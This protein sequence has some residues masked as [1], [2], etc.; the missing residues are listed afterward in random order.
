MIPVMFWPGIVVAF[1][2]LVAFSWLLVRHIGLALLI[3]LSPLPG[4]L[5]VAFEM[6]HSPSVFGYL[7]GFIV[8]AFLGAVIAPLAANMPARRAVSLSLRELWRPFL[9]I[10]VLFVP[11]FF[12]PGHF[13]GFITEV[14]AIL[15]T[16]LGSML[17]SYNENFVVRINRAQE[18]RLRESE[19]LAFLTVPRW[20]ASIS[21]AALVFSALSFFGAQKGFATVVAR[22][23]LFIAMTVLFL[24]VAFF[25]ARNVRRAIA[26]VLA[27][28]PVTLLTAGLSER[29][30]FSLIGLSGPLIAAAMPVLFVAA[31]GFRFDQ[32]GDGPVTVTQRSMEKTGPA[33]AIVMLASSVAALFAGMMSQPAILH[34]AALALGGCAALILQPALTTFLY[35]LFPKRV[36]L[37]E[38]FRRR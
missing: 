2:I 24:V 35:S 34:A 16:A 26:A 19:W 21:G 14:S 20:G 1:A 27:V 10:F 29:L 11:A 12:G 4:F 30:D 9:A 38:A 3:V 13:T 28:V 22:P 6:R 23:A 18:T 7:P 25:V 33:I 17:L 32:N 37:D 5:L 15:F 8:A 31:A 36:S